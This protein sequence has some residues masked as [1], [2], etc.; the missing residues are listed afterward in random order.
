MCSWQTRVLLCQ[1]W[2]QRLNGW[3]FSRVSLSSKASIRSFSWLPLSLSAIRVGQCLATTGQQTPNVYNYSNMPLAFWVPQGSFLESSSQG[4]CQ[5]Q[6]PCRHFR[7]AQCMPE[8]G[9]HPTNFLNRFST[10]YHKTFFK[11]SLPKQ[12]GVTWKE[13]LKNCLDQPGCVHVCEALSSLLIDVEGFVMSIREDS[14]ANHQDL[15]FVSWWCAF[16]S[17]HAALDKK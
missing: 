4:K 17:K 9:K 10:H 1:D 8:Q 16:T 15:T 7:T 12:L 6:C 14:F 13:E 2:I 5:T 11:D 3:S